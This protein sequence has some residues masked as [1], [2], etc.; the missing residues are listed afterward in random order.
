MEAVIL[1]TPL[2]VKIELFE[3]GGGGG[4][5]AGDKKSGTSKTFR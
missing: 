2:L 1:D 3:R 4:E 5:H